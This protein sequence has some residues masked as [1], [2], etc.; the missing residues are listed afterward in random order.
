MAVYKRRMLWRLVSKRWHSCTEMLE[1]RD[2]T[3]FSLRT[4]MVDL[5]RE[6]VLL[7]NLQVDMSYF[8]CSAVS[9][10]YRRVMRMPGD[11]FSD[12]LVVQLPEPRQLTATISEPS[13]I[14]KYCPPSCL[15]ASVHMDKLLDG[16]G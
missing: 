8:H 14:S 6:L 16:V 2:R 12:M 4:I 3:S 1:S 9:A 7:Y 5:Q 11:E 15:L 10:C 13:N